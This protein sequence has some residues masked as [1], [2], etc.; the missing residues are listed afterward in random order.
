MML[1][2]AI[3]TVANAQGIILAKATDFIGLTK[4]RG[5]Q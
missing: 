4:G 2:G 1:G 3:T 5:D